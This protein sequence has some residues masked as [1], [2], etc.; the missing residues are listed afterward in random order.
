MIAIYIDP[1]NLYPQSKCVLMTIEN[2]NL[3]KHI[4]TCNWLISVSRS[5]CNETKQSLILIYQFQSCSTLKLVNICIWVWLQKMYHWLPIGKLWTVWSGMARS[6]CEG[7]WA[8]WAVLTVDGCAAGWWWSRPGGSTAAPTGTAATATTS[9]TAAGR[10]TSECR[11]VV[12]CRWSGRAACRGAR[13]AGAAGNC[14][15]RAA[16]RRAGNRLYCAHGH[17]MQPHTWA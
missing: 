3:A 9:A 13:T 5:I 7:G 14:R 8:G 17:D 16:R 15:R 1:K 2:G 4:E 10:D 11:Y 12:G 6:E